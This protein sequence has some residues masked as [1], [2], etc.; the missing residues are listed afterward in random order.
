MLKAE[1]KGFF[2]MRIGILGGTFNPVHS[3]HVQMARIARDEAALDRV[4]LMV[5]ADPPHKRVEGE[6]PAAERLGLVRLA[7]ENEEKVFPSDLE[8]QRGGKSY[9][10]YTLLE[11]QK[12]YPGAELFLIIG[13]DTLDDLPNWHKPEEVLK[14]AGVLCV[15]RLGMDENDAAAA[16]ALT[17][18]YGAQIQLLSAK[19]GR[20]SSTQVREALESGEPVSNLLP[21][22]VEQA[23]YESG[24]YFPPE[25]RALQQKCR[26]ALSAKRYTHT[27]GTMR[28]AAG[29]AKAWGQNALSARTAALLHDCAKCLDPVTQEVLSGDE[30]GII[31]VCH[32]F[33]GAVL[34]RT[35]YGVTDDAVLR[36]VRLHTT[37][38]RGMTDFDALIYAADLIEPNRTFSGVD[39]YRARVPLGP[40]AFMLYALARTCRLIGRKGWAAHPATERALRYYEQKT[41]GSVPEKA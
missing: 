10:L 7:L 38:D 28:A 23:V 26:A 20:I 1:K 13:S 19:A 29:L 15:P 2:T 4:L 14:T 39:D 9:T 18:R 5:A 30:T 12:L 11:L 31:P 21:E 22:A 33:A 3:A 36:A 8:I 41:A 24:L 34:A 6:V 35:L 32:A 17:A 25:V 16:A 40:D 37:G 27:A